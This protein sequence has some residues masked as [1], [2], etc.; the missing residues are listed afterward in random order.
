MTLPSDSWTA[1]ITVVAALLVMVTWTW[2]WWPFPSTSSRYLPFFPVA[3]ATGVQTMYYVLS[4]AQTEG[5]SNPVDLLPYVAM[6]LYLSS[7]VI[8][9]KSSSKELP[10]IDS[11]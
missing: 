3:L 4:P 1:G 10:F 5:I 9:L 8:W 6:A 7:V 2:K 11:S